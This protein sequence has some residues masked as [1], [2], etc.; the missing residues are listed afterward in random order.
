V[1][2]KPFIHSTECKSGADE[3]H[4]PVPCEEKLMLAELNL[5]VLSISLYTQSLRYIRDG[6]LM[7]SVTGYLASLIVIRGR[8]RKTSRGKIQG[9]YERLGITG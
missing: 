3:A 2:G 1:Q 8:Q 7:S 5:P 6:R 4:R 9:N